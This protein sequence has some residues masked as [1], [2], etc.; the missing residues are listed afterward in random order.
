MEDPFKETQRTIFLGISRQ[1][2]AMLAMGA[3]FGL[4]LA[5]LAHRGAPVNFL[6]SVIL[7]VLYGGILL[8]LALRLLIP[9]LIVMAS[10]PLEPM[11]YT[12]ERLKAWK[13]LSEL[14]LDT[15][16]TD[17]DLGRIADELRPLGFSAEELADMFRCEVAP[18]CVVNQ[19]AMSGEWAGFEEE[20]LVQRATRLGP[21]YH[22]I[23]RI[24]GYGPWLIGQI[25]R[26]AQ[27][28]FVKVLKALPNTG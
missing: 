20:W 8:F 25:T 9:S 3:V 4:V 7:F 10:F 28:D 23:S 17:A 12:P 13:L 27:E 24:P 11:T 19:Y 26:L 5:W 15:D 21:V 22:K 14:Y 2:S 16:H 6:L 18:A 1:L